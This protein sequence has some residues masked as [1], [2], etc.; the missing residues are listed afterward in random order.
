VGEAARK[1]KVVAVRTVGGAYTTGCTFGG[2][3][4]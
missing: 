3:E 2:G 4:W 1:R